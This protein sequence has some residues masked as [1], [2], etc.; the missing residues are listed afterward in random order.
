V[1]IRYTTDGTDP[2]SV[3]SV[4]Y[5]R[6]IQVTGYTTVKAV[7]YKD[8]WLTSDTAEC[9]LF[10][11]GHSP[12][13]AELLHPADS[14]YP[15]EGAVSLTDL[16]KGKESNFKGKEWLGFRGKPFEAM[17]DFGSGPPE[18][19][20]LVFCYLVKTG[21]QI[22]TPVSIEI[23]GGNEK[24]N[25]ELL[26]RKAM[27]GDSKDSPSKEKAEILQFEPANYRYYQVKG[28]PISKLPDWHNAKGKPGW[29]FVD[30]LFF[31]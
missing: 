9:E 4:L 10:T 2:D 30:E 3:S 7:A 17:V 24:Q 26:A 14:E 20:Q 12:A 18:L 19:T 23:W 5:Q 6:P 31:Y 25:M 1:A 13:E 27:T 16:K 15:G 21:S 29:L 28:Q 11:A 22:M 8:Q